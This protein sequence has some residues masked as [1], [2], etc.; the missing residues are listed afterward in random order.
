MHETTVTGHLTHASSEEI[1]HKTQRNTSRKNKKLPSAKPSILGKIMSK[2]KDSTKEKNPKKFLKPT[3]T[4]TH[5]LSNNELTYIEQGDAMYSKE[6]SR[7]NSSN[8]TSHDNIESELNDAGFEED[9]KE[10]APNENVH[11]NVHE[12]TLKIEK[13]EEKQ[14]NQNSEEMAHSTHLDNDSLSDDP[15]A[16]PSLENYECTKDVEICEHEHSTII[17][18][19][20]S[21]QGQSIEKE[22]KLLSDNG[23]PESIGSTYN[24]VQYAKKEWKSDTITAVAVRNGYCEIP[25]MLGLN[26]IL[27]IRGDN[28]C[29]IRA[30]LFQVLAKN[31]SFMSRFDVSIEKI[32]EEMKDFRYIEEWTFAS[33]LPVSREKVFTQLVDCLSELKKLAL[34]TA[35]MSQEEGRVNHLISQFNFQPQEFE[36]RILEATK[37]LMFYKAFQL[38][39][40]IK[41]NVDVPIFAMIMYARDSS[42]D[43]WHLMTKHLNAVG[44]KGGLEQVEM[45]LLGYSLGVKIRVVRPMQFDQ[46]DFIAHYPDD[47]PEGTPVITLVA[48]DDRHYN[49]LI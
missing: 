6:P 36:I 18:P 25:H 37:F 12:N 3:P 11:E 34:L 5:P 9:Y 30:T 10:L 35:N 33:R 42:L 45:H 13:L 21:Q 2:K 48:E 40:K 44:D 41:N 29:A 1:L 20:S 4:K 47:M 31:I 23:R 22:E 32:P 49:V 43:P 46:P 27:L 28:Y 16:L 19:G 14:K 7:E 24:V 17:N 38:H 26:K 8:N 15:C 39:R